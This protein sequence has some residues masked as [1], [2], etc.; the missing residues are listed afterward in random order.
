M[1]ETTEELK[2]KIIELEQTISALKR[3]LIHDSLTGLKTRNFFNEEALKFFNS[4]SVEREKKRRKSSFEEISFIFFDIDFFKN[5]NDT[6]GHLA[7]DEV[8]KAVAR[9]IEGS[10]R[11]EDIACRWGGEEM[12]VALLGADESE[13]KRKVEEIRLLVEKL[14]FKN[15]AEL[16]VTL[17]A[18]VASFY[19]G[20]NFEDVLAQADRALYKAKEGGRNKVVTHSE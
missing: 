11:D 20:A 19:G 13:A 2:N 6:H 5:I 8:L 14:V 17:S 4:I 9:T 16:K 12:V 1:S 15:T 10:I 3:D 18:G 7:G